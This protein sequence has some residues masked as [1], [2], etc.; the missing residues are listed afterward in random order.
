M[1]NLPLRQATAGILT[2]G[3]CTLGMFAVTA[4]AIG[5]SAP[6]S[7]TALAVDVPVV[8]GH[9]DAKMCAPTTPG[10]ILIPPMRLVQ[11]TVFTLDKA[12]R[13][14]LSIQAGGSNGAAGPQIMRVVQPGSGIELLD[15]N[16]QVA[17]AGI[18]LDRIADD[19]PN[20]PAASSVTLELPP[21][22]YGTQV[23]Y[24]Y[25]SGFFAVSLDAVTPSA[26]P[27]PHASPAP[28][29]TAVKLTKRSLAVKTGKRIKLTASLR[30][31]KA[32]SKLLWRS[33]KPKVAKISATGIVKAKRH[34]KTTI[35]VRTANGKHDKL[36]LT[37]R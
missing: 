30:P 25:C 19:A 6:A 26:Q 8:G 12:A 21:G 28:Q 15:V 2:V 33:S 31:A 5:A 9:W 20:H 3:L 17:M 37:V 7:P 23:E 16:G 10:V 18:N 34:G 4:T 22:Q 36:K 14:S 35:T 1:I 11:Q 29:V 27:A 24:G 13:V 32:R